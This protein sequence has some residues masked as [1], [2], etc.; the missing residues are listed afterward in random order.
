MS[1]KQ[2][3]SASIL[4]LI[5]IAVFFWSGPAISGETLDFAVIQ[6]G[7]PGTSQEA[8]PVMDAL[9]AYIQKKWGPALR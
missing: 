6:P 9:S 8:Q 4:F 1:M 7:Q 3:R 2:I 5:A